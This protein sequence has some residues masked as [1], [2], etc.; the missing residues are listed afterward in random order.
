VLFRSLKE[1]LDVDLCRLARAVIQCNLWDRLPERGKSEFI[2]FC[3]SAAQD[4]DWWDNQVGRSCGET[5]TSA[6]DCET[7]CTL[8][9]IP[10]DTLEGPGSPDRPFGPC[11]LPKPYTDHGPDQWWERCDD[12]VQPE[13]PTPRKPRIWV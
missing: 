2:G 6:A 12:P 11:V 9:G 3:D 8:K 1:Q 4:S 5:V 13:H 10:Q 7:C